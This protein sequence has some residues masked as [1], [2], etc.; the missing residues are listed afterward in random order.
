MGSPSQIA[1]QREEW[2]GTACD[3]FV[4]AGSHAPGGDN[5]KDQQ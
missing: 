2:F 5:P 4:L 1:D 3:G